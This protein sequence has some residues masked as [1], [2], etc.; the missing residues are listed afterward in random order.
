MLLE[1]EFIQQRKHRTI[2]EEDGT[3]SV[4]ST[5]ASLPQPQQH[6][7]KE[8][9][10]DDDDDDN[11]LLLPLM[12]NPSEDFDTNSVLLRSRNNTAPQQ[13]NKASQQ[14][15]Q[16]FSS[17]N[18]GSSYGRQRNGSSVSTM[19]QPKKYAIVMMFFA[20][21]LF[22]A[23][24]CAT[25]AA[26][27][28]YSYELKNNGTNPHL[29]AFFSAGAFVLLGFP[30]SIYGIVMHLANYNQP[31]IQVYIIR[32]LWM[33]PIYSMESW[34]CLRYHEKAIYIETLRDF[35]E[36]YVLYSFLQFL[37]Q[38]LGGEEELILLLKDKSPTRGVHMWGLQYCLRPW[39]MGVPV[40]RSVVAVKQQAAADDHHHYH[41]VNSLQTSDTIH[42]NINNNNSIKRPHH[43]QVKWTSPF[44]KRCKFGVLQYVLLKFVLSMITMIL[45][46]KG[47]YKEGNFTWK[48]GYLYICIL[49]NLSQCWALYCLIFF[50]FATVTELSPIRPVGKFLSVKAIVFFTWWQS[51]CI[52]MIYQMNLIPHYQ[53]SGDSGDEYD[54][55]SSWTPEDVAKGLQDYLICIE[56]FVASLVHVFVFPHTDYL[57]QAVQAR[58]NQQQQ[59]HL[60]HMYG[61]GRRVGRLVSQYGWLYTNV[62]DRSKNSNSKNSGVF[63]LSSTATGM[64]GGG[65]STGELFGHHHCAN[66]ADASMNEEQSSLLLGVEE[67]LEGDDVDMMLTM[68]DPEEP[69]V[70]Q[71]KTPGFM[72]ALLDSTIN[73]ALPRDILQ[74]SAGIIKGE[75][76]VEKKTLLQHASTSDPYDLFESKKNKPSHQTTTP[77]PTGT[78]KIPKHQE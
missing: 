69:Q 78:L 38:V 14:Q 5:D 71:E 7:A 63:E 33:V 2:V 28:W 13:R 3:N 9:D 49:T 56:M 27:I 58:T 61:G 48:G 74:N 52:S 17:P 46:L 37:I 76:V 66:N 26:V 25:V 65:A 18:R 64:S 50:Y 4:S 68:D 55:N 24:V 67:A 20:R 44:F 45:E 72:S 51:V 19:N 29:I 15:M 6:V 32:I 53:Y 35:Y 70:V 11:N 41:E 73:T 47:V 42:N 12:M 30:I 57:P 43:K 31:N 23:S 54:A 36:S 8:I 40:S 21:L 77:P 60:Q 75:Y 34:L 62:D 16:P 1:E 22:W 59:Q 10:N 39:L